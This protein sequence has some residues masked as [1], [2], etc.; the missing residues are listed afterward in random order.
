MRRLLD[1][2]LGRYIRHFLFSTVRSY[3]ALF[4]NISC[5]NK[6]L[7]QDNPGTLVLATHV[8]R[9]DGPLCVSIFYTTT[10]MRPTVHYDEYYNRK[11]WLPMMLA[12]A[13]PMSS[14]KS[15]PAERRAAQKAR[16]LE[17]IGKVMRN[18]HSILVFPA[19]KVRRQEQ[20]VVESY[21]SGVQDILRAAPETPVALLRIDGLGRFQ[22]ARYDGFWSFLGI[23]RGRRHVN[24]DLRMLDSLD[25]S[26]ELEAFNARLTDLLNT[27]IRETF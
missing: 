16:T 26:M 2:T 24:M 1:R 11:Q 3:Y 8:S 13:I 17:I 20:E 19:G 12:A 27:P 10:R 15:W 4:Y 23:R 6:H 25:P 5:S 14:P 7:L 18:G 21:F 9:H 22:A